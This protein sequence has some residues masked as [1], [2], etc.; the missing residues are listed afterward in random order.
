MNTIS[1]T[2][3]VSAYQQWSESEFIQRET[4]I[5]TRQ[6]LREEPVP[7]K[8]WNSYAQLSVCQHVGYGECV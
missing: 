1:V 5:R 2:V 8:L 6:W 4:D 7:R 3:L